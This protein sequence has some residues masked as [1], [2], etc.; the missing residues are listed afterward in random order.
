MRV[1]FPNW[2]SF[3]QVLL[4][5]TASVVPAACGDTTGSSKGTEADATA[6]PPSGRDLGLDN[7]DGFVGLSDAAGPGTGGTGGNGAG[8]AG[9]N[10]TGGIG[11]GGKGGDQPVGGDPSTGGIPATG[12]VPATGGDPAT[13]GVPSTGGTEPVDLCADVACGLGAVCDPATGQCV[14]NPGDPCADV[15]CALGQ[16]CENGNCIDDPNPPPAGGIAH[17]CNGPDDCP[18]GYCVSE[19]D[20]QGSFPGGLCVV[21]CASDDDCSGGLCAQVNVNV[22]I[23]IA[24]CNAANDCRPDWTCYADPQAPSDYCVPDCHATGCNPGEVCSDATGACEGGGGGCSVDA[25]CAPNEYCDQVSGQCVSQGNGCQ[26]DLDCNFNETCNQNTG[27]C[28]PAAAA[29]QSDLDCAFNETCNQN[30][31][32]CE[33]TPVPCQ[34]DADCAPGEICDPGTQ[35]CTQAIQ[36]CVVDADCPANQICDQAT[37]QCLD[38]GNRCQMDADCGANET[39]NVRLGICQAA[40]GQGVG[41]RL[42]PCQSPNDCGP[43]LTCV[44]MGNSG[45]YCLGVCDPTAPVDGCEPHEGCYAP[46]ANAPAD[47]F[48]I[49]GNDCAAGN[50]TATCGADAYCFS[51][52][53]ATLCAPAGNAAVGEACDPFAGTDCQ[54]DLVCE[55]GACRDACD[56]RGQCGGGASCIDLS[57]NLDGLSYSF[58]MGTCGFYDQSGCGRNESCVVDGVGG[59]GSVVAECAPVAGG[60]GVEGDAC[61]TDPNTYWGDCGANHL[62]DTL[63]GQ[64]TPTSCF[65]FCDVNDA[66]L[67]TGTAACFFGIFSAPFTALGLCLGDCDVFDPNACGRGQTCTFTD[68]VGASAGAAEAA[69]SFCL[70]GNQSLSVGDACTIDQNTGGSDCPAGTVCIDADGSGAAA[71]HT[72]CEDDPRSPNGCAAGEQCVTGLGADQIGFGGS[73]VI[74]VCL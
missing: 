63:D 67:C 37:G 68:R 11:T 29:C 3:S 2:T 25:D 33:P 16:H 45:A 20:S 71:C 43:N 61:Q 49:P 58:C 57:A 22:S 8:G 72:V 24:A 5:A 15:A 13:G 32:V 42:D 74:G 35:S 40:G 54:A 10:G 56:A 28:E 64:G 9:G 41:G 59:D 69:I 62:C 14:V 18:E 70:P 65:G 55:F 52:G 19:A 12:G 27:V 26:S 39:C 44:Q 1:R 60:N 7:Y 4:L 50:A 36:G 23:C 21:E 34:V 73:T 46:D 30:T 31:G 47:G 48:C 53:H 6:R 66:S 38:Q 51:L 17:G